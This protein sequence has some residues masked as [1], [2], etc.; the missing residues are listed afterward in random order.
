MIP[1][2]RPLPVCSPKVNPQEESGYAAAGQ[3]KYDR[4]A[5]NRK[6]LDLTLPERVLHMSVREDSRIAHEYEQISA[7][8][9]LPSIVVGIGE[10]PQT[11]EEV[12]TLFTVSG[13]SPRQALEMLQNRVRVRMHKLN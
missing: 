6:I 7:H 13:R 8:L 11:G 1:S 5:L 12:V 2:F 9:G 3:S 10:N 4:N